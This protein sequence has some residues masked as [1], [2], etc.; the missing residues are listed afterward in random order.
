MLAQ[1]LSEGFVMHVS[2][3]ERLDGRPRLILFHFRTLLKLLGAVHLD[4]GA[5]PLN[6][7]RLHVHYCSANLLSHWAGVALLV[8]RLG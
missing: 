6:T 8:G 2:L 4:G 3:Q 7:L 1:H 5:E